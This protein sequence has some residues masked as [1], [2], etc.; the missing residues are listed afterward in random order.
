VGL[1]GKLSKAAKKVRRAFIAHPLRTTGELVRWVWP[2]R[3]RFHRVCYDRVR[4]A[5]AELA[6]RVGVYL[7]R[8]RFS[9]TPGGTTW[10]ARDPLPELPSKPFTGCVKRR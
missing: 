1:V 6:D 3:T 8:G 4:R 9:T 5:A 7:R 10:L 2:R